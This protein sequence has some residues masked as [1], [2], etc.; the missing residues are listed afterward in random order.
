MKLSQILKNVKVKNEYT[1]R[2]VTDVTSDSR[3][4]KEGYLFVCI[5]GA[6]FDG[7]SV[8]QQMLDIG[9]VAV[10]CEYDL[11]VENQ[12]IVDDTRKAYSPICASFFGN[13]ADSLKLIGLTGT[14]GKTTTTFLIKQ[15]LENVGKKVGLIGTVQNMVGDEVYPAHYT[16]PDPHELQ[17]LFRKM[18]DAGCEYCIMEVSSQALAQGRV[19]GIHF[20]IGAFTNLTQDHLDYHKTWENY[21]ESKKLLFKACDC[22]VTNLDDEYGLKIVDG[23]GC[24]VVT[25]GV[26]NMKADFVARNV[27][28]SANGVRYDLVGEKMGRVSCPIPGR[29]SVYNSLCA[30]SVALTLGVDFTDVLEA[31]SKSKGVKGRIE[32][33]PTPNQNY[34]VI[35]DYAH[36]PDGL[37]NIISSL[38]EIAN[39]RVVTVFGCGGDRD[40]TKRPKMGKIAA[41]LSDFCV[42]TSDNP[43]SENPSAIIE[44]ILEGMKDTATP[45]EVVENRKEAIAWAMKN[46][47]PNDIILLAGKGHETY[48]ILPTGTI[49]FDEREAVAE[50][51]EELNK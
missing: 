31:I 12:I 15:I 43:R 18:V 21:F 14:N 45:Y 19:E 32:V 10:V 49:H 38:K 46:A 4:V 1:D 27:G 48:Q 37:E 47:Q 33:V 29:F 42:V 34:T 23:C 6:S 22:A 16:T 25:Y 35:I 3:Q 40:R 26:D 13:P 2:E 28:F 39:G 17:S 30:T 36:S 11:G 9:A 8:A 41:E 7:H 20:H 50:V 24:R 51:L 44:D 5:K